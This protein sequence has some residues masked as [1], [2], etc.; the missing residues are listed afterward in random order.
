MKKRI[1][2]LTILIALVLSSM[3]VYAEGSMEVQQNNTEFDEE[4]NSIVEREHQEGISEEKGGDDS[5]TLV[6][7]SESKEIESSATVDES[8]EAEEI[9][10]TEL[11]TDKNIV[12]NKVEDFDLE[13]QGAASTLSS[14]TGLKAVSAGKKRV[15]LTW[16]RVNG[17]TDYIIYRQI[18]NTS[19]TYRYITKNL[20]YVDL[21][22]SGT[23]YNFYRVYASY[24]GANNQR[25]VG[26]SNSYVFAK[27]ILPAA[28]NVRARAAGARKVK[29]T[30]DVVDGAEG[31][32]IYR[33]I[34]KGKY[35]YRY[36]TS[37]LNYI[38]TTASS[39]E[40]NFYW[41]FPYYKEDGKMMTGG[42]KSYV[43][44]KGICL[45][46]SGLTTTSV[47]DGV[48]LNWA[49]STDAEGYLIYRRIGNG[50]YGYRYMVTETEFVDDT[51]SKEEFNFYWV[52]PYIKVDGKIVA[53]QPSKYVYAKAEYKYKHNVANVDSRYTIEA[54]VKLTGSGTGYHAK[55]LA[56]TPTSAV[57]F[58]IQYDRHA[59]APYTDR[60]AFLIE[61]VYSNNAGGQE[62]SRTG[63]AELNKTF[64]LMLT[65]Q[66]DGRCDVY[67]D[68]NH[69]GSVTNPGLADQAV[70]L[71]VEG[72]GRKDGDSVNA[73]FTNISLKG[74][75]YY[76]A[77]KKWGTY[78][79]DT[80]PGI[81][82]DMSGYAQNK[83]VTINGS[84]VG[85]SPEQDWD[86]A[87]GIVSGITQ[88]VE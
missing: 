14:V 79:F 77:S 33:Q 26:P 76:D 87:Y 32:L 29:L 55:I 54:D 42:V 62:Y 60:T 49:K 78:N 59:I 40:Y 3:T 10:D 72:S 13:Q 4:E 39:T 69:V 47:V 46:V 20:S 25:V 24:M 21:T 1:I 68:G 31:Y 58:G 81:H 74:S 48:R 23:E 17:A 35:A 37:N 61:N 85:L 16:N 65:V 70:Y 45:P 36:M 8:S 84:V 7:P 71:R 38:D 44:A 27:P 34:G 15:K 6:E 28:Q 67:V 83:A 86:N 82:S 57:S 5:N 19:F 53:G 18:G 43:F 50:A 2:C 11:E 51:A 66:N 64:H 22:A 73:T 9:S 63:Y 30:W 80:N 52:F 41:V 56:C 75:G 12:E 88:F